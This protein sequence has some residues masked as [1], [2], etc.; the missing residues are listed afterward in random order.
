[1]NDL[2]KGI[3]LYEMEELNDL[4]DE[5]IF[6]I[7][8]QYSIYE[9]ITKC[10]QR[11]GINNIR[12]LLGYNPVMLTNTR[13]LGIKSWDYLIEILKHIEK[14]GKYKLKYPIKCYEKIGKSWGKYTQD[15]RIREAYK[16]YINAFHSCDDQTIYDF[17]N[18]N[19]DNLDFLLEDSIEER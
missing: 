5:Y 8:P 12:I 3:N 4:L 7:T 18:S 1:M 11:Q 15:T 17:L 16:Q 6:K 10:L 9:R 14:E 13:T 19:C 2:K